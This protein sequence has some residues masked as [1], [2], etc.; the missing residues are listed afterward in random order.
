MRV[1]SVNHIQEAKAELAKMCPFELKGQIDHFANFTQMSSPIDGLNAALNM[2]KLNSLVLYTIDNIK[3]LSEV[4]A[5]KQLRISCFAS[6]KVDLNSLELHETFLINCIDTVYG[7]AV[8]IVLIMY[9]L[10]DIEEHTC[11][12]ALKDAYAL[13]SEYRTKGWN[14]LYFRNSPRNLPKVFKVVPYEVDPYSIQTAIY[15]QRVFRV[16]DAATPSTSAYTG[17]RSVYW[18][19]IVDCL[20]SSA[21]WPRYYTQLQ[22]AKKEYVDGFMENYYS[23]F[24]RH[25]LSNYVED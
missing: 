18:Q 22:A 4:A 7:P 9:V 23:C 19:Y 15:F 11:L 10:G 17:T 21:F 2:I 1:V 14:M 8:S 6:T 25:Q 3:C 12:D 20:K 5:T 13:D 24:M 16:F